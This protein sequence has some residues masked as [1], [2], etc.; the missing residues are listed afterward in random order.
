MV[1]VDFEIAIKTLL[2]YTKQ[3]MDPRKKEGKSVFGRK[4][5]KKA[6]P[7]LTLLD[8]FGN[9]LAS[10]PLNDIKLPEN[11]L[12]ELSQ[13]YFDDPEPCEIHR[14]AVRNRVI[15]ELMEACSSDNRAEISA[16]DPLVR[17]CFSSTSA[18]Y[19]RISEDT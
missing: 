5:A 17:A 12:I 2:W 19:F 11:A 16:L 6:R 13:F 15:G 1:Y 10:F 7:W 8:E 9:A 3:D 4:N 18:H 14:A